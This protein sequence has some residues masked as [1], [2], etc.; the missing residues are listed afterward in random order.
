MSSPVIFGDFISLARRRLAASARMP[1]SVTPGRDI[2][3]IGYG[4]LRVVTAL[5][6]YTQDLTRTI[7]PLPDLLLDGL[8]EWEHAALA[9]D[10]ALAGAATAL[11]PFLLNDHSPVR[12]SRAGGVRNLHD[13][14]TALSAGRDLLQGHFATSPS[15]ARLFNSG[16]ALAITSA[17]SSRALLAEVGGLAGDAAIIA[18]SPRLVRLS[19]AHPAEPESRLASAGVWLEHCRNRVT[20]AV[21]A[22]PNTPGLGREFLLSVPQ[23][24]M[25]PRTSP[26]SGLSVADL[27]FAVARCAGRAR[28]RAWI[29][30][31]LCPHDPAISATSWHQ[32]AMAGTVASHNVSVLCGTLADHPAARSSTVRRGLLVAAESARESRR[33]WLDLAKGIHSITT[34]TRG[35]ISP[36]AAEVTDL[37]TWTG[38]LAYANPDWVLASGPAQPVR[39]ARELASRAS[40][41]PRV[42]AAVHQ[43]SESLSSLARSV[44]QQVR[45]ADIADRVVVPTSSL[46]EQSGIPRPFT[47][48]PVERTD[49][50]IARVVQTRSMSDATADTLEEVA[51]MASAPSQKLGTARHAAHDLAETPQQR[52]AQSTRTARFKGEL[53]PAGQIEA[54]LRE[55]G[56]ASTRLLWRAAALDH[57][58]QQ[59]AADAAAERPGRR[60]RA[61]EAKALEAG[62]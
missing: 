19:G 25:P 52:T 1:P 36:A 40:D 2:Q 49:A 18:S 42:V 4:L 8:D 57:A 21:P 39:S 51:A 20:S 48:A 6:S 5:R 61:P 34:D 3:L 27:C 14:A 33:A 26:Q 24:V 38:R 15:G 37:A 28:H 32:I 55:K 23:N 45:S 60:P 11:R 43:T 12:A 16:W 22:T 17:T 46:P 29:A 13:A 44:L 35:H 41:L 50:L 7:R 47:V 30:A 56:V 10:D 59:L 31:N 62:Q 58:I 53:A 54:A 9:A